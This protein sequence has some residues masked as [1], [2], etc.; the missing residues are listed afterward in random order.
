MTPK[1]I[2]LRMTLEEKASLCS[3]ADLWYLKSIEHLGIPEIMVADGPHGL[4]KQT[5]SY[6]HLGSFESV[7]A[8][9][10]PAA[11][12]T[13][14]SFDRELLHKI[15]EAIAEECLEEKVA[16]ILGPGINIKRSPLCGRNFE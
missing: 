2:V 5:G 3:G 13:V 15:G 4:R 10:F 9:C 11:S 1:E 16:I 14:C 6:D 8:V 12:T 7:P